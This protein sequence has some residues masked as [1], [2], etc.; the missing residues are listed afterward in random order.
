MMWC[1]RKGLKG[2]IGEYRNAW[3]ITIDVLWQ[4]WELMDMIL[5]VSARMIIDCLRWV[6]SGQSGTS[7]RTAQK[8]QTTRTMAIVLLQV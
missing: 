4:E 8:L 6:V 2:Y 1:L 7:V 5:T 3:S